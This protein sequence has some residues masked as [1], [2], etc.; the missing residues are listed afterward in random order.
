MGLGLMLGIIPGCKGDARRVAKVFISHIVRL[1]Y[2]AAAVYADDSTARRL[3]MLES[4]IDT[5]TTE[6]RE[7]RTYAQ[8]FSL[9]NPRLL[10]DTLQFRWCCHPDGMEDSLKV[11][12]HKGRW[13]VS[14]KIY[15][16]ALVPEQD[17][18]YKVEF[19]Y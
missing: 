8:K 6:V 13:R 18:V 5:A 14:W 12:F 10:G 4:E 19:M 7:L 2:G 16:P 3:R 17:T 1:E 9:A 15:M 11:Y